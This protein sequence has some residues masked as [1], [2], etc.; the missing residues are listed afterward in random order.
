MNYVIIGSGNGLSPAVRQAVA[1]TNV[2]YCQEGNY[3]QNPLKS[4]SKYYVIWILGWRSTN[5]VQLFIWFEQ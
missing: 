5:N 3:K 2:T 1:W 4:G